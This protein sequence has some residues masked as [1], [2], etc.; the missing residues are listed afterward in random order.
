MIERLQADLLAG[1]PGIVHGFFT[2]EGGVSEGDFASL[3]CGGVED[4]SAHV[5]ENRRR[6]ASAL[7]VNALLSCS[8]VHSP[9]VVTVVQ[10]WNY[11]ARPEADAMVTCQRGIALGILT[12]DCVPILFADPA[13]GVI[14]AAHAGWKGA[15]GG[16]IEATLGTMQTLGAARTRIV[17]A[18]GPCIWQESY[19]VGP[20][21]PAPFLAENGANAAF[22]KPSSRAGHF[23]F[24]LPGYV[25]AKVLGQEIAACAP[26]P[27]DTCADAARFFSYRRMTL[28][29][30]KNYGRLISTIALNS[31]S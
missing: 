3:N 10:P 23:L 5:A 4:D 28:G 13:A 25:R 2:R 22:F 7:G 31:Q 15:V 8:Q 19:E 29:G 17:A 24:D 14:G 6:V 1:C 27:A 20:A 26:S 18:L 11:A 21:F 30:A 16:V 12:A 9:R